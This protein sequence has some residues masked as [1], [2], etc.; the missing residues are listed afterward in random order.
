MKKLIFNQRNLSGEITLTSSKSISNRLQIIRALSKSSFEIKNLSSSNDSQSLLRILNEF[1][2]APEKDH[3]FNV[4]PAGTTMRFLTAYFSCLPC[5]VKI[6]GSERMKERPI[7]ELVNALQKLGAEINYTDNEGYPP[8]KIKGKILT[9]G[10]IDIKGDIS[11]QYLTALLLIAPLLENGM[12]LCYSEPLV[13]KP[14]LYMTIALMEYFG[15]SVKWSGN[16]ISVRSS[17]YLSKDITVEADWSAASYWYLVCLLSNKCTLRI[18]GLY[19]QSLQGDSVLAEIFDELGVKTTFSN[20]GITITKRENFEIPKHFKF[21]FSNCPD[22]AQTLAVA[23]CGLKLTAQFTGLSTLKVKETDRIL[24]LQNELSKFNVST[25]ATSSTLEIDARSFNDN[26][27]VL[28]NTY[29]DHRMAMAFAPLGLV[30]GQI[31][32]ENPDVVNKSYPEYWDDLK[33]I[34]HEQ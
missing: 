3:L 33:F 24:A 2:A 17:E 20:G 7:K 15:A 32:I 5:N 10:S 12:E 23:I 11:S 14:Y 29:H 13:S 28:I 6:T 31:L 34:C 26:K 25:R 8:L 18:N 22:I 27:D 1:K 4:G 19:Q 16:V 30:T 9:G 21:D